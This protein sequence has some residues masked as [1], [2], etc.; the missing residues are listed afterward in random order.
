MRT[1]TVNEIFY[2]IQGEGMRW[3]TANLFLRFTGCNLTCR[4]EVEG[5]DC[6]TEFASGRKMDL[7]QLCRELAQ[8]SPAAK[9]IILT[10]GEPAL[11]VNPDLIDAL[12]AAGYYL[13]IETNGT[14]ELPDGIDWIT[15]SPKTAEHTIRVK[16]AN[17]V[18]YVRHF[19]QG[20]PR[21]SIEAEHKLISPACQPGGVY[22]QSTLDWCCRMVKENPEWRLSLQ[23]HKMLR[24]R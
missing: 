5:F 18:K 14:Y 3:G 17:E 13:A 22:N 15:V 7:D 8:V 6:D 12:K 16:R 21:P 24:V 20:L 23:T 9:N 11:Q 2:S 4:K 10:G 19:G 1:Y